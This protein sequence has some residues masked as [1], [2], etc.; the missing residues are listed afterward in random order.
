MLLDFTKFYQLENEYV[1]LSPLKRKH[2]SHLKNL[3]TDADIWTYFLEKGQGGK[4]FESYINYAFRQHSLTKEYPFIVFD[5]R[6]QRYAGTTRFYEYSRNLK[7]IKLGHTWYGK[8]FRG[9]G[10]NK[11]CKFLL[12]EFAFEKLKV[13]RVGLEAYATNTI[14]IAA[15][16]SVGCQ[17]EGLLR[18]SLPTIDGKGRTDCVLFSILRDE[19]LNGEKIKLENKMNLLLNNKTPF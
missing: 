4:A 19:W 12:F 1:R 5:K 17:L 15:M 3:S 18:N 7:T 11:H 9:T 2:S 10:I 8:D 13:E 16:K 14:S 6:T